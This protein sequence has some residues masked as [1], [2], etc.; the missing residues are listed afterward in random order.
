MLVLCF[1]NN[2]FMNLMTS[3]HAAEAW[4]LCCKIERAAEAG[5][6]SW[7]ASIHIRLWLRTEATVRGCIQDGSPTIP[8]MFFDRSVKWESFHALGS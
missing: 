5:P 6:R 8:L 2:V 4:K 3:V 1:H 7:Q